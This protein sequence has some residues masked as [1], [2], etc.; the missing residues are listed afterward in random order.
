ME[1]TKK[2]F[3]VKG[4]MS[5]YIIKFAFLITLVFQADLSSAQC[6]NL[7]FSDEFDQSTIDTTLWKIKVGLGA[8]RD[9][10]STYIPEANAIVNGNL[11]ITARK[12][13]SYIYTTGKLVSKALFKY[14]T[15]EARIKLPEGKGMWPAFWLLAANNVYGPWPQ[16]GEIDI[17]ENKGSESDVV[18]GYINYGTTDD[19]KSTGSS[20]AKAFGKFSDDFHIYKLEWAPNLLKWYVDGILYG[21]KTP[22][23]IAPSN[24]PFNEYFQILITSAIGGGY[25]GFPDETTVFPNTMEIDYVHVYDGSN[26][27][28]LSGDKRVSQNATAT[29]YF[30]H[31]TTS[32]STFNWTVPDGATIV[33]GNNTDSIVVNWGTKGGLVTVEVLN[34]CG[35]NSYSLNVSTFAKDRIFEDYESNRNLFF[36]SS[37]GVL[38]EVLSNPSPNTVNNSVECGQYAR[39]GSLQY[40]MVAFSADVISDANQY[41]NGNKKFQL[42]VLSKAAIG[43]EVYIQLVNS[44][45]ATAPYPK[46]FHS[47][48]KAVTKKTN[49]WETLEFDYVTS[50]D[51]ETIPNNSIDQIQLL[52]G[53]G[54]MTADT[55][56][57]DNF[58]NIAFLSTPGNQRPEVKIITPAYAAQYAT[59]T[60]YATINLT[61]LATDIDG[62]VKRVEYYEDSILIGSSISAPYSVSWQADSGLHVIRAKAID[63]LDSSS[64]SGLVSIS[65]GK[66][67]EEFMEDFELN[68]HIT[69]KTANGTLYDNEPNPNTTGQ[70]NQSAICGKYIRGY[71]DFDIIKYQISNVNDA[72]EYLLKRKKFHMDLFTAAPIGSKINIQLENSVKTAQG[73]PHGT[74]SFYSAYTTKQNEWE[75]LEFEFQ[76]APDT[77]VKSFEIDQLLI[78]FDAGHTA[79]NVFY[80]DNVSSL[81]YPN[82]EPSISIITP[83]NFSATRSGSNLLIETKVNDVDGR[84]VK[85]DF[86]N[87]SQLIGTSS[88]PPFKFVYTNLVNG[89]GV[90]TAIATDNAGGKTKSNEVNFIVNKLDYMLDN[91]ENS[92]N[93]SYYG[94]NGIPNNSRFN[95]ATN[96]PENTAVNTSTTCG[97]YIRSNIQSD[98]IDYDLAHSVDE[99]SYI[100]SSRKFTMDVYTNRSVPAPV[101]ICLGNID[102]IK[103]YFY[104]VITNNKKWSTVTFDYFGTNPTNTGIVDALFILFDPASTT[105]DTFH[106]DNISSVITENLVPITSIIVPEKSTKYDL[107]QSVTIQA[108]A[109]DY[110][111]FIEKVEFYEGSN[112][113]GT[114]TS[115]PFKITWINPP[116]GTY[117]ITSKAIDNTNNISLSTNNVKVIIGNGVISGIDPSEDLLSSNLIA[118]PNP[119][120]GK[121]TIKCSSIIPQSTKLLVV[122]STGMVVFE[123][124]I[125]LINGENLIELDLSTLPADQYYL[126]TN[127]NKKSQTLKII[128][129]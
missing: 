31:H 24:W 68:R 93:M 83:R 29:S 60:Q 12:P 49:E 102:G 55:F 15:F 85:V 62:T 3:F 5:K 107:G 36:V 22:A 44:R 65:V 79:S 88:T 76:L 14:G 127:N 72:S 96:N 47:S 67:S 51:P 10:L 33:S 70:V 92:R 73:Y 39:N 89:E 19:V 57:I 116:A 99:P 71:F 25:A 13:N 91:F 97:K 38:K 32:G 124:S 84:V 105:A 45:L 34:A 115:Q 58:S 54:V 9:E 125:Y 100:S 26:T 4:L 82:K 18:N 118:Y 103:H 114:A 94:S 41:R 129:E 11:V 98:F 86:Y 126:I 90:F 109:L 80:Y 101:Y 95:Q 66:L 20:Y 2:D 37:T 81:T 6:P 121:Y 110:D 117:L 104:G 40:D 59:L 7:I 106:V 56:Y 77:T 111:G 113:I 108:M 78:L 63:N 35:D 69:L 52:L 61:S 128:K 23:D 74:H 53:N 46:G 122:N 21:T 120:S 16:S 17:V 42:D 30:I 48:Y 43:T 28:L 64:F 87:K 123:K 119:S 112:L 8:S 1:N 50:P 27:S 75:T